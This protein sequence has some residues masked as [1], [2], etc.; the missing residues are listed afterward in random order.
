MRVGRR[1]GTTI[2]VADGE[3][4]QI[5]ITYVI[6]I[7]NTKSEI[8]CHHLATRKNQLAREARRAERRPKAGHWI[9]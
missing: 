2:G 6:G 1:G 9:H 8:E 7:W 4:L 3:A 5:A